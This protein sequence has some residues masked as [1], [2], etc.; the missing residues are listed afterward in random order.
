MGAKL[1]DQTEPVLVIAEQYKILAHDSD[2]HRLSGDR[3]F[4]RR[5][6]GLPITPQQSSARRARAGL[7]EQVVLHLRQHN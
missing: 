1:A 2:R 4:L 6:D 5:S 3:H 7:R